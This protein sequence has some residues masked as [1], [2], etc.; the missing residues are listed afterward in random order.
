MVGPSS[1]IQ[2][3]IGMQ[4]DLNV[5]KGKGALWKKAFYFIIMEMLQ[6]FFS[7]RRAIVKPK[8][9]FEKKERKMVSIFLMS[10]FL[11]N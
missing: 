2:L 9:K 8:Q 6:V 10:H 3:Q 11:G 5:E 4:K 7:F 1:N